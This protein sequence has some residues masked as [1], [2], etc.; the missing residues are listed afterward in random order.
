M[1][2]E[3]KMADHSVTECFFMVD[4]KGSWEFVWDSAR[5]AQS[6]LYRC[7]NFKDVQKAIKFKKPYPTEGVTY[8]FSSVETENAEPC[9]IVHTK[10]D[11]FSNICYCVEV[12]K[13]EFW[14]VTMPID[15]V[16][17]EVLKELIPGNTVWVSMKFDSE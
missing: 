5:G 6:V 8:V 17:S 10:I 9:K 14:E 15:S 12:C 16:D 3:I 11:K 1:S 2:K 4:E 13:D 7:L